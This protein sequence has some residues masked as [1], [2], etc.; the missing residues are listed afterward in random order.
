MLFTESVYVGIDPASGRKAFAYAALD[1]DLNLVAQA[2]GEMEDLTAFLGGQ[3]SAIVA[4]NA[5]SHVNRGLVRKKLE[6]ES[7]TPGLH[8]IRGAELRLA[9]HV[10]RG[11][12]ISVTGTPARAE[13]CPAW[14]QSGFQLYA[15]LSKLGFKPFSADA[16]EYQWLE[17][18]PHACFCV[19]LEQNPLPK[20]TLEGRLQR[21]LILYERGLRIK[22]PMIFFEEITRFKLIR[23][24]L[25]TDPVY[26]AEMLDV[27]VA[28]Y[29][30]WVA[31]NQPDHI[32][33]IGDKQEGQIVL[34]VRELKSKY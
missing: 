32:I 10:L 22:D 5:P 13:S 30:A 7:L 34:P 15:K 9:E 31:I 28:A 6:D 27:L 29:T 33:S 4:V 21:Q 19:L 8:Q 2:D 1:R 24:I 17:T 26:P 25:P 14:M 11:R 18:H 12:G 16:A 3:R 23:G 20:P